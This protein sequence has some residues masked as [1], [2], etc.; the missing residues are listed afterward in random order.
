M[1]ENTETKVS[2]E[3]VSTFPTSPYAGQRIHLWNPSTSS[4][5]K[6]FS[7]S[8]GGTGWYLCGTN[9]KASKV[10]VKYDQESAPSGA[11]TGDLWYNTSDTNMYKYSGSWSYYKR[12]F[13]NTDSGKYFYYRDSYTY[14]GGS[15]TYYYPRGI[16]YYD[17]VNW[18]L[19]R[20]D[21]AVVRTLL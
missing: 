20:Q 14:V 8:D 5:P 17:G 7:T 13:K 19:E 1:W 11:S 12:A 9:G 2:I 3:T 21:P 16:Y 18:N 6:V 15:I 10:T 4:N